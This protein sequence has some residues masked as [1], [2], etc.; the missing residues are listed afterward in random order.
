VS[1]IGEGE[2]VQYRGYLEAD[3]E[4]S[5]LLSPS[6]G[7]PDLYVWRP[8]SRGYP[9]Y[10]SNIAG[11]VTDTVEFMA[12]ESGTYIIEVHGYSDAVYTLEKRLIPS[13]IR[14]S[15]FQESKSLPESPLTA[16]EPEG[17]SI[18]SPPAR[19]NIYLPVVLRNYKHNPYEPNDSFEEA[20]GPLYQGVSYFSYPDDQYD[21]Y[22]FELLSS[23]SVVIEVR[24][25][26]AP[27]GD[28]LLYD[29]DRN[30][31]GQWG[32]RG[33][34]MRIEKEVLPPGRYYILVH[35]DPNLGFSME[36]LYELK[37]TV[38]EP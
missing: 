23:H 21:Y 5:L 22:F 30:L 35:T 25:Y 20:Y 10:W 32:R 29:E 17:G 2:V 3:S 6:S 8:L 38:G 14:V 15:S 1:S 36:D 33:R 12:P 24:N 37:Y 16:S 34:E 11:T 31:I 19:Y 4:V 28:L 7:D 18:P 27:S 26:K 13:E 9:D